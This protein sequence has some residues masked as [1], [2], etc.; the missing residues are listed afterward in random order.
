MTLSVTGLHMPEI[1]ESG[2]YFV[3]SLTQELV[4]PLYGWNQGHY[5]IDSTNIVTKV[6]QASS[7][8][9]AVPQALLA[10]P[11]L[12]D[13]KQQIRNILGTTAP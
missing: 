4:H 5:V 6:H 9:I 7:R 10:A 1:R 3:E 11:S 13:F 12:S 8:T 2:V